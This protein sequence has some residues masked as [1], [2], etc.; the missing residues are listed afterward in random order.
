M[1]E[2]NQ[3]THE[4]LV[5]LG[6]VGTHPLVFWYGIIYVHQLRFFCRVSKIGHDYDDLTATSL[7]EE[8]APNDLISAYIVN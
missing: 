1:V 5:N 8:P 7:E 2:P 6:W 4:L 3:Q